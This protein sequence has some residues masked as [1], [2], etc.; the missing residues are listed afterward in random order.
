MAIDFGYPLFGLLAL[1]CLYLVFLFARQTGSAR[2]T[3]ERRIIVS[4]RSVLFLCLI[5]ALMAP[6]ILL[7]V[8]GASVVFLVDRSASAAAAEKTALE[9]IAQSTEA[10]D[11]KDSFAIAS[12]G[13]DAALEQAFTQT[14]AIEELNSS[15]DKDATNIEAGIQL[16]SSLLPGG[17]GRIV[18]LSDGSQTEGR[19]ED[20][21]R[22]LRNKG[23]ELDQ[24]QLSY[25][26]AEDAALTALDVP[27]GLYKGEKAS[28]TVQA[29]SNAD[30][31]AFIRLSVND[32][33]AAKKK[34]F[35]K[36]G[37]NQ[38]TFEQMVRE[39]GLLV[40]KAEMEAEND[41]FAE[42]NRLQAVTSVKG[43]PRVLVVQNSGEPR[44]EAL[45]EA[46]G[47]PADTVAAKQLPASLPGFLK[48]QSIIFNN[49]PATDVTEDQMEMMERSVKDFGRGFI[50]IG[51]N[52]SFGLGGYFKT[53]VE[54]LLPVEMEIKGKNELPSLGLMIVLDRS[55]SME[56]EKMEMAKEAAARSV[57]LLRDDDTLGFIAFDDSPW[58]VIKPGPLKDREQAMDKI[59]SIS[60]G[61]G[62]EIY[63]SLEQA[64]EELKKLK[65]KRKH[66][67]LLTDG[68]SA[69]DNDY[70]ALIKPGVDKNITL[71]SVSLGEDADRDL[72]EE[73]AGFGGG[74]F[75]DVIDASVIPSILSRETAMATRT[76]IE[77]DPFFPSV[78]QSP[79]WEGLFD[80]GVP[81]MNAYIASTLK[82]RASMPLVSDKKDPVLATWQ[83]GLGTTAAYTSDISGKWSGDWPAWKNWPLFINRLVTETLPKFEDAPYEIKMDHSGE[84]SVITVH[85]DELGTMPIE[86]SVVNETGRQ[87]EAAARLTGPGTYDI[88]IPKKAGMYFLSITR[89]TGS[90][91]D[92]VYETGITVPYPDEY[93]SQ[94]PDKKAAAAMKEAGGGNML[95]APRE[96]FRPLQNQPVNKQDAGPYL[97]LLAF[98]LFFAEI[99]VRRFGLA[100]LSGF[101]PRLRNKEQDEGSKE[102]M[103]QLLPQIR[104]ARNKAA[105]Q[106]KQLQKLQKRE[107][108]RTSAGGIPEKDVRPVK[109]ESGEQGSSL[110]R[111]LEAKN[112]SRK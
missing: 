30:K 20:A 29:E 15:I 31:E 38:F 96:A 94:G 12:F 26:A 102:R 11:S 48:Y 85:S 109:K 5:L 44:L 2:S 105:V 73:L 50:M 52:E 39:T 34:V 42:N 33:E 56:G 54:R 72:L 77:D 32:R 47:L 104:K 60:A 99:T 55:G 18:L 108:D 36:K 69:T 87:V 111:L 63:T 66:I 91:P 98:L 107:T 95:K 88:A 112:R 1:P 27:Q 4:L 62:T 110:N 59:R 58:T 83:Y 43:T 16:A 70:E 10:K 8:K 97:L 74:R 80:K 46:G 89:K 101:L 22:L 40:Y 19:A 76:Y 25:P 24:A 45:L 71:S 64:Y 103:G 81:R 57:A 84:E 53:P 35:L 41:S 49:I 68:Q 51:G 61:G 75:Y 9:W 93:L 78:S 86:A 13:R 21:V 7:P 100:W 67:I 23:I 65:V 79:G 28:I 3:A 37:T 14:A 82:N 17:G 106:P 90:G 92:A 6:Q